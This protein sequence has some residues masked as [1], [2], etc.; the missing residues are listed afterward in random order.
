LELGIYLGKFVLLWTR[1][2]GKAT[3]LSEAKST[4]DSILIWSWNSKLTRIATSD[5][6]PLS[7]TSKEDK[8][9]KGTYI[10]NGMRRSLSSH[11]YELGI[12]T[13]H[14][15][16]MNLCTTAAQRKLRISDQTRVSVSDC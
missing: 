1:Q 11:E 2:F 3:Y 14:C 10:F 9:Q 16:S 4:M 8:S 13:W 5:Q 7:P 15:P 6:L 12:D